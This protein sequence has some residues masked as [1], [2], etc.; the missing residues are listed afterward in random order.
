MRKLVVVVVF[1]ALLLVVTSTAFASPPAEANV[2]PEGGDWSDHQNP[3]FHEVA[4]AVEYCFKA[5]QWLEY[6][7]PEGG[8]GQEGSCKQGI[9]YCDLSHWSYRLGEPTPTPDPTPEPTPTPPECEGCGPYYQE[10]VT[11]V[12]IQWYGADCEGTCLGKWRVISLF[13]IRL[14][15]LVT[16]EL[17]EP[18]LVIEGSYGSF[19][20][21]DD[22]PW[23]WS[24]TH[25]IVTPDETPLWEQLGHLAEQRITCS[26]WP[27]YAFTDSGAYYLE[28]MVP[29]DMLLVARDAWGLSYAEALEWSSGLSIG[30]N[31]RPQ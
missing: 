11:D 20:V 16:R 2:C 19:Y 27:Y 31:D 24:Y 15:N 22:L 28:G 1:L 13:D 26:S 21:F 7:Y 23:E 12:Q 18:T 8:F 29:S 10:I 30:W 9:Q 25:R 17:I 6:E 4:G 5:G 14:L 3:P